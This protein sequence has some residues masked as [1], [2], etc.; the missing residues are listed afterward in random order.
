MIVA[1]PT[2]LSVIGMRTLSSSQ[3]GCWVTETSPK[4]PSNNRRRSQSK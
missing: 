2:S 4:S 3:T 1:A